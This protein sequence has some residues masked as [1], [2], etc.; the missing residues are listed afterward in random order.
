M[1][2]KKTSSY[3]PMD[4]PIDRLHPMV[5]IYAIFC[6]GISALVC[7]TFILSYVLVIFL[8]IVAWKAKLFKKF[9]KFIIGFAIPI[10]VMLLFIHGLY[11]PKNVTYIANFGFARL[12]LEGTM[13]A[14][15]LVGGLLVFLGSFL[16]MTTTTHPGKLVTALIES[17]MNPKV[18]YLV[19]ASLNIVPQMQRRM[20]IIK[21]AQMARGVEVEG[22][23]LTRA[24]AFIPLI[25]P[26]VMSSLVDVQERGMTLETRG[27]GAKGVKTTSYIEVVERPVDRLIKRLLV[28]FLAITVV[29]S[30][31]ARLIR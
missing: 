16:L 5:K 10:T 23:L 17:G 4:S 6:L 27:F 9:A 24:T 3:I 15:K 29:A 12:G 18:G 19:L 22:K 30:I 25:G 8:F 11:S 28:V 31:L 26:L 14:I 2:K 1:A 21:E 7:P 20:I 13:Y